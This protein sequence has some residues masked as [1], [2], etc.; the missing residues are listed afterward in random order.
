MRVISLDVGDRR[1]G[2]AVSDRTGLIARP[3]TILSRKG[4]E[5]DIA[6]IK[7]LITEQE[8]AKIIVGLPLSLD[9]RVGPQAEKVKQFSEALGIS[10][11][12]PLELYDERFSTATVKEQREESGT[13]RRKKRAPDDAE[14]A[15]IILRS[16]LDEN[17]GL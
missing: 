12:I 15:A 2:V 4:Q 11:F 10:L 6:A 3:L 8:A 5:A 17:R 13:K 1:I 9:G 7:R 16:Y 14:A